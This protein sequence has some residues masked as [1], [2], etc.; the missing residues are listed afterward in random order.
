MKIAHISDTHIGCQALGRM[1]GSGMN[2]REQD[3]LRSFEECLE[4][5]EREDP[6]LVLHTGDVFDKV[7]PPNYS[8]VRVFEL[9]LDFQKRRMG[10]PLILLAGNHETPKVAGQRCILDLYKNLRGVEVI[11]DNARSVYFKELD[12][13]VVGIPDSALSSGGKLEFEPK[14]SARFNILMMHGVETHLP[15]RVS[16]FDAKVL[17]ADAWT[18]IA[19]G[20]YHVYKQYAD[21][22]CYAGS[23]EFTST[24]PWSE[25]TVPKGWVLF[26]TETGKHELKSC[27]TRKVL[28]LPVIDASGKAAAEVMAE[29]ERNAAWTDDELPI[30]R[31][32]VSNL[33]PAVRRELDMRVVG[34][35][36]R[37]ALD[38]RWEY[39]NEPAATHEAASESLKR[40]TIEGEWLAHMEAATLPPEVRRERVV[41]TGLKL[42]EE[43][44]D[45]AKHAEAV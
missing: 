41:E 20:D 14:G 29:A 3:V 23:T 39:V 4:C 13:N 2:Q 15:A 43:E 36:K 19:L 30:V 45:E 17:L 7:R 40:Q 27:G 1:D 35:L 37:R 18:Y 33:Q 8:L 21:N 26:D 44:K 10:R 11:S 28:D 31:Q 34:A 5:I 25:T 38:Y 9:L 16:H 32:R 42:L 6:D 24:D 22:C 12:C